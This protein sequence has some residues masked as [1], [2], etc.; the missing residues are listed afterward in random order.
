[1]LLTAKIAVEGAALHF[2]KEY[3]YLIPARLAAKA[4]AGCRVRV[5]FGGGN[6]ARTG[7]I[8]S[9]SEAPERDPRWKPI[10]QL[11]DDAPV[12]GEEGLLLMRYLREYT[13]CT[14]FDALRALIPAG[15][16]IRPTETYSLTGKT[17][18]PGLSSAQ[19]VI[20]NY[21]ASRKK[22]VLSAD[23]SAVL[24]T[25]DASPELSALEEMGIIEKS[26]ILKRRIQDERVVMARLVREVQN[27]TL[28]KRQREAV[29]FLEENGPASL[30][31]LCYLLAMTRAVPDRLEK[32]GVIEYYEMPRLRDPYGSS[33][34]DTQPPPQLS[35]EQSAAL[36]ELQ[37]LAETPNPKPALLYGV[38][39]S[40]KTPVYLALIQTVLDRGKS[41]IVLVP[42]ISLTAQTVGVFHE[43]FGRRVTVLH[44]GLSLGERMDG[45]KRIREGGADIVI[46]TR[47]A[48]FAPLHNIG[49]IVIDEEQE[50]TYHSEKSPRYHARDIAKL[51][52]AYHGAMLL[53]A[54]ATPS[55]ESY[56]NAR[57]GA[58]SLVTLHERYGDTLLPDVYTID[59]GDSANLSSSPIFSQRLLDELHYNLAHKEQSILLINRRGH[60]TLLRCPSCGKVEECPFCSVS[61]T[62]HTANDAMICHYCGHTKRRPDKCAECGSEMI[63]LSGYG[64]QKV[65]EILSNLY[66]DAR[67]LRVDMDT[68]MTK[69]S[70]E[71]HFSGFLAG[72][73]DIMVG[74]QM[75]AKGLNF[76]NVTLVGAL[77]ADQSLYT[78]DFRAFE[79]GFALLTQVIGRSGR[80][81]KRG[82]A[83][84]QTYFPH[85]PV[86]GF[87][88]MQDYP[89]FYA[90]EILSRKHHL[91]P[92]Y[93]AMAGVG[94]SGVLPDE[95]A[96][97]SQWFVQAFREEA[98][99][100][101][102]LP[103]RL[104]GPVDAD[105][106]KTAG[107]YRRKL[108][109]KCKNNKNTRALIRAVIERFY[110][111][112]RT[113]SV[114]ADMYYD[115]I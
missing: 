101:P 80:G 78:M 26:E 49:L 36:D 56:Y 17:A 88:A 64:T 102:G 76:P 19:L 97:W 5:P 111:E 51:R 94:F 38:T 50:H 33:A 114:F 96:K 108:I 29:D 53:L 18:P 14:W 22:P 98:A 27:D 59:M 9:V 55:V 2:D 79:K 32:D 83:L 62:Y 8:L 95:V 74:T 31:E 71:K 43:C 112:C 70:H 73:Y 106:Y 75:V 107:K 45:W 86:I 85:H 40:G 23:L 93:C 47:S 54:S 84:I 65:C 37:K 7:F 105:M 28:T 77:A 41:V 20:I 42:E 10:S 58:Y 81:E 21:L 44:S 1:M 15:I 92:P 91:Y 57:R 48:V 110:K 99:A 11:L 72:E 61:L 109:I 24:E 89:G 35:R 67:I 103:L 87:A 39:G 115:R 16:G 13:F 46:G 12:V 3:S 52:C 66:P 63:R 100:Y 6:R 34:F 82:R 113:V 90:Q 30:K 4:R 60:S 69:F 104:L 68:T 25:G